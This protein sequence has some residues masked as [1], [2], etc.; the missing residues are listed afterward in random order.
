MAGMFA[1]ADWGTA[2]QA[3]LAGYM[4][5]Q[6]PQVASTVFRGID[7]RRQAAMQEQQ[8][9][10]QRQ[11]KREDFLWQQAN[12][13]PPNNDTINDFNFIRQQLGDDAAK[14][15]LR[16]LGDPMVTTVLPGN[17]VYSGPRS[18]LGG[19]LGAQA[20]NLDAEPAEEDGFVYTPGPGGRASSQ[21]WKPKGGPTQP[22]SGPFPRY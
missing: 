14:Q 12:Q 20:P 15:Y 9:Q 8:Y 11:D 1:N 3:A 22:A 16:N 19:A 21:N 17:R 13:A 18:Q 6:S 5:R 2:L 7:D 10:R 4:A